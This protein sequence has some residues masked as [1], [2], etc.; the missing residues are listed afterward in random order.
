MPNDTSLADRCRSF[1]LRVVEVAGWQSRGRPQDFQPGGS[2]NHHTAG[3]STGSCPSLGGVINGFPGS[4]PGPL[5]N[6]VQ[7]R[8]PDGNDIIYIVAAG[9]AN[10]AGV[11]SWKGLTG[12]RRVVG[13]EIEHNGVTDL[14]IH[15]QEI[16]ARFHAAVANGRW[17]ADMVC[18][19]KE[20]APAGTKIDA[21]TGVD[22]NGFRAMVDAAL[23]GPHIPPSPSPSPNSGGYPMGM[24]Q[25]PNRT[26]NGRV[27]TARPVPAFGAIALENG[28]SLAGDRANGK[29]RI[30]TSPD[31]TVQATGNKLID[32]APTLD[33]KGVPDGKGVVATFVLGPDDIGSYILPWS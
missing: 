25:Q 28:A 19:H 17:G 2:V 31:K 11:G 12:N 16:A 4:A 15:R 8:E 22:N 9:V 30:W 1:G 7:S 20:W 26:K 14:P 18:Q 13:L 3:P 10:H 33:S 29:N 5:A 6:A 24:V 23:K 21:A 32:I 27:G